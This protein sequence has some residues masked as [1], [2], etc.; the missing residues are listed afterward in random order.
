MANIDVKSLRTSQQNYKNDFTFLKFVAFSILAKVIAF[1]RDG[2]NDAPVL[3]LSDVGT[4]IG[5]LGS[6]A[7]IETV[8]VI[9][10][11]D[12]PSRIAKNHLNC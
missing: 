11:T 12:Q 8:D 7:A 4:A 9:I 6:Y 2:I 3:V 10:Q 5:G 1:V